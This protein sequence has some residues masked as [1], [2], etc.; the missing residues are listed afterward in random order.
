MPVAMAILVN[1][2][3]EEGGSIATG[4]QKW[5]RG[6]REGEEEEAVAAEARTERGGGGGGGYFLPART[7]S[8]RFGAF[9]DQVHAVFRELHHRFNHYRVQVGHSSTEKG[10]FLRVVGTKHNSC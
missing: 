6:F 10:V 9:S 2:V 4:G 7:F 1:S 8:V 5:E 3:G